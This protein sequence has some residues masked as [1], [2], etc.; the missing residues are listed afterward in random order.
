MI[1][2]ITDEQLIEELKSRFQER[3][4]ALAEME[5]LNQQLLEV[6]KKLSESEKLKSNF[7]SN[8]RNEIIN[9]MSAIMNLSQAIA[10]DKHLQLDKARRMALV[11][12]NEAFDL[13]FQLNNIFASA[14]IEAGVIVCE[15]FRINLDTFIRSELEKF[16]DKAAEK[17]IRLFFNNKIH[18]DDQNFIT[19]P[20]KLKL[21]LDNLVFNAIYWSGKNDTVTI[22]ISKTANNALLVVEDTG[23]GIESEFHTTIFDRFKTVDAAVHSQ[24]KGHGLGLSIVKA[25]IDF[26]GGEVK[27]ESKKP[28]GSKFSILLPESEYVGNH[29]GISENGQD[30]LFDSTEL[31]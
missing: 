25:C 31:F 10:T 24:N 19:D 5:Q 11:I 3:K 30:F 18:P 7:L 13:N 8:A 21:I 20:A 16:S 27:L 15:Q 2:K 1:N 22:T 9:P 23:P 26:L 14:E 28:G 6:N 29:E 17:N 12:F 4:Q